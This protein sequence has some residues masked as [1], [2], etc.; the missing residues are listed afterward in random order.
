MRNRT[1]P[2]VYSQI[3]LDIATRIARGELKEGDRI[4]GRSLTASQYSVSPETVRRSFRLLA[5]MKILDIQQNS[6]A[7]VLSKNKAIQ[8]IDKFESKKD[9]RLLREQLNDLLKERNNIN[10]RILDVIDEII[11]IN[12][13][14]RNSDP[15]RSYEFRISPESPLIGKT[16]AN[17][18]F[19]QNTGATIV[20]LH[21]DGKIIL[22][23]GPY[24]EF[25]C[26]DIIIVAGEIDVSERVEVFINP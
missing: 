25:L 24:A 3:A 9:I 20:A 6:G 16:I 21:R 22:S 19:W 14:F 4:S 15:L 23:P 5:D 11:D 2:P 7:I 12:E 8:Y 1:V 13:R 26:D 10:D 18:K 17:S